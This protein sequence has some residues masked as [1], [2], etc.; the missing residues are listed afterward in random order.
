MS[1]TLNTKFKCTEK[2]AIAMMH[3]MYPKATGTAEKGESFIWR[4]RSKEII[5]QYDSGT[6]TLYYKFKVTESV[7]NIDI[8]LEKL[9]KDVR[10]KCD[11]CSSDLTK[12]EFLMV[13][14]GKAKGHSFCNA[15]CR[16]RFEKDSG[17]G[18]ED[19]HIDRDRE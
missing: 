8:I 7:S 4:D 19:R 17:D 3:K 14:K 5:G 9:S 18:N 16:E 6:G 2:K 12:K 13:T 11:W 10:D 15:K 1:K